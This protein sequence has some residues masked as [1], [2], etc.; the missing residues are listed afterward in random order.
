[1]Y[2]KRLLPNYAVFDEQ[3]YFAPAT[4]PLALFEIAGVRVG[5]S[6]CEDAWSPTGPIAEQAA[7]APS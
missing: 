4:E 1:M 3:R 5:V 2:R 6:I 7:A